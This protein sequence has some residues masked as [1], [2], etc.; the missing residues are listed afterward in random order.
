MYLTDNVPLILLLLLFYLIVSA[1]LCLVY[2]HLTST[3]GGLIN[4]TSLHTKK[5]PFFLFLGRL[6][7]F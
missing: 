4:G 5:V 3:I 7:H 2:T 6:C 1:L